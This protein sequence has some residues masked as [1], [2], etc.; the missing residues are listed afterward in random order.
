MKQYFLKIKQFCFYVFFS[1]TQDQ[2]VQVAELE[3]LVE[4]SCQIPG[5]HVLVHYPKT[6]SK[7]SEVPN[8]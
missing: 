2:M 4:L 7:A 5:S 3:S 6:A 1:L 8:Q